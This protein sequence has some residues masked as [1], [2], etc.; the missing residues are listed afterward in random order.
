MHPW[1]D[2]A[3]RSERTR[4]AKWRISDQRQA[5]PNDHDS[6]RLRSFAAAR[7]ST[8]LIRVALQHSL[9]GNA[10][11]REGLPRRLTG[12]IDEVS[13]LAG[14][15]FHL[16]KQIATQRW[17]CAVGLWE[18]IFRV[19]LVLS[20][21]EARTCEATVSAF[22]FLG[23]MGETWYEAQRTTFVCDEQHWNAAAAKDVA[24]DHREIVCLLAFLRAATA[25]YQPSFLECT[26]RQLALDWRP[27]NRLS[28]DV[29]SHQGHQTG[30]TDH[31]EQPN[32]S[33][34]TPPSRC[35][36]VCLGSDLLC[37]HGPNI[38]G[39]WKDTLR[40]CRHRRDG[41]QGRRRGLGRTDRRRGR[42]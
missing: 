37:N 10:Q 13:D 40:A 31:H 28:L 42:R 17:L 1:R 33:S 39:Q 35:G 18:D 32:H 4:M 7:S 3:G 36:G 9:S 14:C 34:K 5:G 29:P 8:R 22:G 15:Q 30:V 19:Q 6:D 12:Q 24:F 21:P 2:T 38:R 41:R 25:K 20:G 11:L 23:A 16:G 27:V 26:R